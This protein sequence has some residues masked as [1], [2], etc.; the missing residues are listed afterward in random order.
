MA[1]KLT[2]AMLI[3]VVLSPGNEPQPARNGKQVPVQFN[4]QTLKLTYNNENKSADQPTG[5]ASQSAS[6]SRRSRGPSSR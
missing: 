5:S 4:P 2:K 6:A 1:A 3:Q